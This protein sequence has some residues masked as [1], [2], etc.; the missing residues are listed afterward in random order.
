MDDIFDVDVELKSSIYE[1]EEINL[2]VSSNRDTPLYIE[3]F[4]NYFFLKRS[5]YINIDEQDTRYVITFNRDYPFGNEP[6]KFTNKLFLSKTQ[7][8]KRNIDMYYLIQ[9]IPGRLYL[10]SY[11]HITRSI[12]RIQEYKNKLCSLM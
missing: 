10:V 4:D 8:Q 12:Y 7:V 11:H 2:P 6:Y 5:I 1:D 3:R 9:N